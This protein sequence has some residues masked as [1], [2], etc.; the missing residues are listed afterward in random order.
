MTK[1][2]RFTAEEVAWNLS[3][4]DDDLDDPDEPIMEGSDDEFSELDLDSDCDGDDI[5]D[6]DGQHSLID[7]DPDPSG[8]LTPSPSSSPTLPPPAN[9]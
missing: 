5:M 6:L 2:P 8:S 9:G 3:D 7:T 1:R 4:N